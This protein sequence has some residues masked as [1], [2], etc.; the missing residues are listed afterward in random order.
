MRSVSLPLGSPVAV[1]LPAGSKW[2][3][4]I[5]E[6]LIFELSQGT[7]QQTL[8]NDS[9]PAIA[10]VGGWNGPPSCQVFD[11]VVPAFRSVVVPVPENST[12]LYLLADPTAIQVGRTLLASYSGA[13]VTVLL[14]TSD[15]SL[16][17]WPDYGLQTSVYRAPMW[18]Y[19]VSGLL[20]APRETPF[21]LDQMYD[22]PNY[23]GTWRPSVAP[24]GSQ[25]GHQ[26]AAADTIYDTNVGTFPLD[27]D[28]GHMLA[29]VKRVYISV[30]AATTI[31]LGGPGLTVGSPGVNE[32]ARIA[33]PAAGIQLVDF[34]PEGVSI[35]AFYKKGILSGDWMWYSTAAATVDLTL[36][37]G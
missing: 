32:I 25:T 11:L 30:S 13:T 37:L 23:T 28:A 21:L 16:P 35:D 19:D 34:G 15:S 12:G 4:I 18:S 5:N 36:I 27:V 8:L 29:L 24:S 9:P 6:P 7:Q 26:A 33:F 20:L 22:N 1:G 17:A 3:R 14:D 2:L 10:V 31:V